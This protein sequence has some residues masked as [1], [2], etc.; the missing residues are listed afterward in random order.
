MREE[1]LK[2]LIK[3]SKNLDD[4]VFKGID[5]GKKEKKLN[6]KRNFLKKG[7]MVAGLTLT[8]TGGIAVFNPELV[9]AIPVVGEVFKSFN[10]TLFGEPTGKF[11]GIGIGVGEVVEDNGM[12]VLLD[13]VI[14]DENVVMMTLVVEGDFLKGFTGKN[15]G[16]F[17][18][19]DSNLM[20]ND[21]EVSPTIN[22][23]KLE[24]NKGAVILTANVA[25]LN[26]KEKANIKLKTRHISRMDNNIEGKWDFNLDVKNQDE[27]K[28]IKLKNKIE[29]K[30]N[31]LEAEEIVMTNLTNTLIFKGKVREVNGKQ[32]KNN[33][34]FFYSDYMIRDNNNKYFRIENLEKRID[35]DN[36]FH[37][38]M[39]INGDLSNS[40]Y[41]ELIPKN[42]PDFITEGTGGYEVPVL[43][44]TGGKE[45]KYE[46]VMLSRKPTEEEM[47]AGYA[48]D[49]VTYYVNVDKEE[50]EFKKLS[51]LIGSS[52]A[53]NSKENIIIKD[54]V[55]TEQ[56]TKVIFESKGIYNY[57]NLSSLVA[58]DESMG[59]I[60]R[61][62]GQ[63]GAAVEDESK[64]LYSM[65]LEKLDADKKYKLA[66]PM[67]PEIINEKPEWSMK[68]NLK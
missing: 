28:R 54:I 61:R 68:I 65:T 6:K 30:N 48:L 14:L 56:G 2:G 22:V 40:K 63:R 4:A 53:V 29:Y 39:K 18:S 9:R 42:I 52:I 62:E 64:G 15:E 16:D 46:R 11:Q 31:T 57:E 33:A 3:V 24:E 66:I 26:I 36:N 7:T 43:K 55:N 49:S 25:K 12:K 51:E 32:D 60:G 67:M 58:F 59:D 27:G 34:L 13:E 20:V 44:T 19:L 23:R 17:F 8:I 37:M 45:G 50:M 35:E 5:R 10:S 38:T 47:K 41:I 1:D 21:K